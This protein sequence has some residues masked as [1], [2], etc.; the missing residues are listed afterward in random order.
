[1]KFGHQSIINGFGLI[2]LLSCIQLTVI[3]L[4]EEPPKPQLSTRE[5]Q[6]DLNYL[7][8]HL[9]QYSASAAASPQRLVSLETEINKARG[10]LPLGGERQLFAQQLLKILTAIDDP[11]ARLEGVT[12]QAYLPIKLRKLDDKWLALTQ[13]NRPLDSEAPFIT[14]IDGLPI[15]LWVAATQAFLPPSLANMVSEQASYLGMIAMLRREIGL[16]PSERCRLTLS[17]EQGNGHQVSLALT[18]QPPQAL[19]SND[20]E[21]V[22][23][24]LQGVFSL[25][26]LSSF[27]PGSPQGQRLKRSLTSPVTILDLRQA[28]GAGDEL[29]KML[30]QTF[31]PD[32]RPPLLAGWPDSLQAV[33][34]YKK[35][36]NLRSDYLKPLGF[37]PPASLSQAEQLQLELLRPHLPEEEPG[38][39]PWQ[40]KFWHL[41]SLPWS[42]LPRP[43]RGKLM[44]LIGP[45]CRQQC[46]WV[47][48]F[49]KTWPDTLVVGE[50]TRGEYGRQQQLTLPNSGFKIS[51]NATQV[52]DATGK[53]L[54]GVP[55]QPDI[56]Q[57]LDDAVYW[58]NL[59][60]LF[61]PDTDSQAPASTNTSN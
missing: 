55:T 19:S 13:D 26:D 40:A 7:Q 31:S 27:N 39:S 6:S 47:A 18:S 36:P 59:I 32:I 16:A 11:S 33:A 8:Q 30:A 12:T 43:K 17:D 57:P 48:H 53:A 1:M 35:G 37:L 2:M 50:A 45:D 23:V 28:H 58:E 9:S 38:F 52:Y 25:H 21:Q 20:N 29:L 51:F 22:S 60:A 54:S 44:L 15:A 61:A 46:Q 3:A 10:Q 41:A 4:R 5:M 24:D 56:D 34:R 42:Y 49:A 14:H